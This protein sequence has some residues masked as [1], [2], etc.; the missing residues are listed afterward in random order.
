MLKTARLKAVLALALF[1]ALPASPASAFEWPDWQSP[2]FQD[3]PLAGTI[4]RG[5]GSPADR[6]AI[7]SAVLA[8][9]YVLLGEIHTNPDH[10]RIQAM[11][12]A[13]LAA[14]G[15]RPAIVFEMIPAGLQGKLDDYLATNPDDATGL[16]PAVDW[17]TRGWPDWSIYRPIAEAALKAGLKMKAGDLDRGVM[18]QIGKT[19]A[20]ALDP[21]MAERFGLNQP[22]NPAQETGLMETLKESH[23]NL[24]P[25]AALPPMLTV[26]RARDGAL[27]DAMISAG[28][29][30]GAVL[31]AGSGHVRR[32]WAAAAVIKS[33]SP[34]AKIVSVALIEVDEAHN[35]YTDYDFA[36]DAAGSPFDY[37]VFTPRAD[38]TDHCAEL[39]ER[40]GKSRRR[41]RSRTS[42]TDC[43]SRSTGRHI[44]G[45]EMAG[46]DIVEPVLP[47]G[48]GR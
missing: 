17:E 37:V 7:Y 39:A 27:A 25:Q 26:Q 31:I 10:H 4:W 3:H 19:G 18:Q 22:L 11:L 36:P 41:K 13:E 1:A 23:C 42:D 43:V 48:A 24:L 40:F 34:D 12:I 21:A 47:V 5:D 8:A 16:G 14:A 20:A 9:D 35:I 33:R 30:G 15:R 29:K 28:E 6:A 32:D 2:H 38:L 44:A 45:G 46:E